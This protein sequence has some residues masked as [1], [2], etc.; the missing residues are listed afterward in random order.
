MS[1]GK[2][3]A[4]VFWIS[5]DLQ[6]RFPAVGYTFF[7]QH[8]TNTKISAIIKGILCLQSKIILSNSFFTNISEAF[9]VYPTTFL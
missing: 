1:L 7:L 8:R 5:H 9:R 6:N 2:D 4:E 3:L